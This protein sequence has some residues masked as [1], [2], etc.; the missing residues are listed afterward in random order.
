MEPT[1]TTFHFPPNAR[2]EAKGW[3]L[4]TRCGQSAKSGQPGDQRSDEKCPNI[5]LIN[6]DDMAWGDLTINNPS[7]PEFKI[8]YRKPRHWPKFWF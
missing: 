2:E 1:E 6:T 5:I 7:K 3:S 4:S 8:K